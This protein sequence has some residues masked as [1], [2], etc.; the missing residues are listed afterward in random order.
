MR[1]LAELIADDQQAIFHLL[2]LVADDQSDAGFQ[3]DQMRIAYADRAEAWALENASRSVIEDAV[4]A[5]L[6]DQQ[7]LDA[8]I[9]LSEF[10][11]SLR[12]PK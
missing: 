7:L 4:S 12:T 11:K 10:T 2:Q 6:T 8:D 9:Y 1:E 3:L 5:K